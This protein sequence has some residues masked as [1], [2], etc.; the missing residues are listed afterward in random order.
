MPDLYATTGLASFVLERCKQYEAQKD[1]TGLIAKLQAN[2]NAIRLI[3]DNRKKPFK[4]DEAKGW[5]SDAYLPEIKTK[6][7][8]VF[9]TL[10][11]ILYKNDE[12]QFLLKPSPY[13]QELIENDP[14]LVEQMENDRDMM[15]EKIREQQRDF[16]QL[17]EHKK[18]LLSSCIYAM[19]WTKYEVKD[20]TR[21]SFRQE[22]Y[23]SPDMGNVL[24][25]WEL[26][27]NKVRV[28]GCRYVSVWNMAWDM[29]EE[30]I[31]K[32]SGL[33]E[34]TIISLFEARAKMGKPLYLDEHIK[35]VISAHS[36]KTA[37][38]L[39]SSNLP[40]GLRDISERNK[41]ITCRE[42]WGRAPRKLV[43]AFE[44]RLKQYRKPGKRRG[45]DFLDP[46][47]FDLSFGADSDGDEVE[48]MAE[49]LDEEIV[50]FARR[51][52]EERP[53]NKSVPELTLDGDIATG[54]SDNM[55][56]DA[57][58]INGLMRALL[59]N[60]RLA[61][62]VILAIKERYLADPSQMDDGLKPG[63]KINLAESC[64]K[65]ADAIQQVT[66]T[67]MSQGIVAALGMVKQWEDEHSLNPKI[68]QGSVNAKQKPD[69]AYELSQLLE[70]ASRYLGLLAKAQDEN[71]TV[72]SVMKA[73]R[74]NME[75]PDFGGEEG[76]GKGNFICH[77]QGFVSLQNKLVRTEALL[78]LMG[79]FAGNPATA[80][81]MD[82]R[83]HM[84]EVYRANNLD[85]DD[86]LKSEQEK[87]T[88]QE[89]AMQAQQQQ[90]E[91]QQAMLEQ[92]NTQKV[93]GEVAKTQVKAEVDSKAKEEDFQ[94]NVIM[95]A[96]DQ[97]AMK[98][99]E[100]VRGEK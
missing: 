92:E 52:P 32:G 46:E 77:A 72:P 48:I 63:D 55:A 51:P 53:Y 12:I 85:P 98:R 29:E 1:S 22:Q 14:A 96:L 69:T 83:S 33:E 86:F 13:E 57:Y 11:E 70:N 16:N 94:R 2:L 35:R 81:E 31:Q 62:N 87:A 24:S 3:D 93:Q 97:A 43:D 6:V 74:F 50:R 27:R 34:M 37:Q 40:P 15:E 45:Y 75:D 73:W 59:D 61:A 4:K 18:A 67:D 8:S 79:L 47:E 19:S 23:T 7:Y 49:L 39:D 5:R 82:L 76:R 54:L 20:V 66:I 100:D 36:G 89:A 80:M 56:E 90:V 21:E 42:F 10:S 65:A 78:K 9:S 28:P 84:E 68:M 58:L 25:S 41:S 26:E 88:E 95:K 91:Q 64:Q 60:V 99:Q 44:D 38:Q 71:H 17:M 30:D